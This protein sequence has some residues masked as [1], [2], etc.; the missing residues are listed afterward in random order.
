[1]DTNGEWQMSKGK[2]PECVAYLQDVL[3]GRIPACKRIKQ[4]AAMMLPRFEKGYKRWHFDI[5][6]AERPCKFLERFCVLP[7][8]GEKIVLEPFQKMLIQCVFGFVDDDGYRQFQETLIVM[9]RKQGKSSLGA[10]L[11]LYMLV[12]DGEGAP[13]IGCGG[14]GAQ[15]R[16]RQDLKGA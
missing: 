12:A 4:L 3:D 16:R 11:E 5:E 13:A 14:G 1:M 8:S 15:K 9:S 7:E 6:K 2:K 10:A